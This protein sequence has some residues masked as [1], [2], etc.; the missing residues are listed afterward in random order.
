MRPPSRAKAT[1]SSTP[2]VAISGPRMA[3]APAAIAIVTSPMPG[4]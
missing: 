1:P 4:M 2:M 3:F